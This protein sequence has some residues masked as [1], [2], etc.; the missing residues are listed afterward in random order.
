MKTSLQDFLDSWDS[1]S[2]PDQAA[3]YRLFL[4]LRNGTTT[5]RALQAYQLDRVRYRRR[6]SEK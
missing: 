4:R 5:E 2:P 6:A 1:L 3:I